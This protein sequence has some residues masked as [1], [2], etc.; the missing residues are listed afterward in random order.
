[1]ASPTHDQVAFRADGDGADDATT[2]V[3]MLAAPF[4]DR[5]HVARPS[6]RTRPSW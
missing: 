2:L 3:D 5:P 6:G 1:M 4:G